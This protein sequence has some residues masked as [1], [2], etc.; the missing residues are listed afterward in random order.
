MWLQIEFCKSYLFKTLRNFFYSFVSILVLLPK[1]IGEPQRLRK[2]IKL[3]LSLPSRL[4]PCT[5][6]DLARPDGN[7]IHQPGDQPIDGPS[8]SS[9]PTRRH[10]QLGW[11]RGRKTAARQENSCWWWDLPSQT[12][13]SSKLFILKILRIN[14]WLMSSHKFC[15]VGVC[16]NVLTWICIWNWL[17]EQTQWFEIKQL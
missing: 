11:L 5:L 4:V 8:V 13:C 14:L 7:A 15:L 3:L 17:N 16:P 1:V 12:I 10:L 9:L 2:H 6:P